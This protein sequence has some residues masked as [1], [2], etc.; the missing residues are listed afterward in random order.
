MILSFFLL[1]SA[2]ALPSCSHKGLYS[3]GTGELKIVSTIFAP[4]DVARQVAKDNATYTV[5]QTSGADLHNYTP[6]ADALAALSEA[7][8]FICSGGLSDLKW[9]DDVLSASQN[10]SLTVIKMIDLVPSVIVQSEGHSH[11][12]YCQANHCEDGEHHHG[13]SEHDGH[14]HENDEHVWTSIKAMAALTDTLANV[15]SEKDPENEAEYQQNATYYKNELI[16]LDAEYEAAALLSETKTLVFAD[17]FPFIRLANDYGLCYYSAFSGCSTESD[18]SFATF[19]D[20]CR[21]AQ[22]LSTPAVL[23]TENGDPDLAEAI[24]KQ[25]DCGILRMNSMQSVSRTDI[26]DGATYLQIMRDNLVSFRAALGL[27]QQ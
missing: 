24:Q 26:S 1:L 10:A 12:Q 13:H 14:V 3:E 17:R 7:D 5:L 23:L 19:A 22:S 4:F 8:V 21:T 15:F 20:L 6:T 9:L 11:G 25:T 18:A 27:T 16:L 2:F